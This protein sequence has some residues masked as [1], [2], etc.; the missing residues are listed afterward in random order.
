MIA[1]KYAIKLWREVFSD[2][3]IPGKILFFPSMLLVFLSAFITGIV[4]FFLVDILYIAT[5]EI[6][7]KDRLK[8]SIRMFLYF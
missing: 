7:F 6:E 4:E 5:W 8:D 1:I 3:K 2:L